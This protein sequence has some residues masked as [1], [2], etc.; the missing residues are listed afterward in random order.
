MKQEYLSLAD[1]AVQEKDVGFL[2]KTLFDVEL[3]P[4]QEKIVRNIAFEENNRI[5]LNCYTRYGKTFAAGIGV[6]L[7]LILNRGELDNFRI[8]ILGPTDS[9]A[10]RVR[11]EFLKA[12]INSSV[13]VEMLDTSRGND[14]E[15]LVKSSNKSELTFDEGNIELYTLSAQSGRSG[16]GSGVMGDGVD[17]LVMD[18]SNRISHEFWKSAGN[19]LLETESAV[20]VEMGNPKHKDNQFYRHWTDE[21]FA[22]Y[23]VGEQ[24]GISEGRHTCAWFDDKASEYPQGRQSIDYKILYKSQ[25][26]DQIE[27]SLIKHSWLEKARNMKV[28]SFSNPD[29][30]YSLDVAD[31][32][33]DFSVLT[34]KISKY[35][36]H[37]VTDQWV[38][39][40]S[41]D[42]KKTARWADRK[43]YD[44]QSDVKSFVVDYVGIGAGTWSWLNDQ[45]YPA[46]KFKAGE[47]PVSDADRFLNKKARCY[48]KIHDYLLEEEL[49]FRD[50]FS[51]AR[52]NRLVH[53]L[54]HL[55]TD[56]NTRD[57][58]KIV[59][60]DSGSPDF[61]DSLM[62]SFYTGKSFFVA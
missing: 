3:Y 24:K 6:A 16:D 10:A 41:D 52:N 7:Y 21:S 32:G 43:V 12:G 48:F 29:I 2:C 8:G 36:L 5:I 25:F 45:G 49:F 58:V 20:L 54:T 37:V 4:T 35:D 60:P 11:K 55:E 1:K 19:R 15:D 38:L 50:G 22:K 26:P 17:L 56:R 33:N 13:F 14:A 28:P 44:D 18:E 23:H 42:P 53:E 59:D 34:R 27:N 30:V 31:E 57:K 40:D 61:A 39:K 51:H 62:M 46:K 9:D 47:K